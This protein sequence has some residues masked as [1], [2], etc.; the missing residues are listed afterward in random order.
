MSQIIVKFSD[1]SKRLNQAHE[2]DFS[3]DQ[4]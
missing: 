1:K 3:I 4:F 2:G